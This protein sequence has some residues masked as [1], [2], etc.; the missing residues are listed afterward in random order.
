MDH[1]KISKKDGPSS[2]VFSVHQIA[3]LDER[4]RGFNRQVQ[5][6]SDHGKFQARLRYERLHI[7]VEPMSSEKESLEHLVRILHE[8]GYRQLRTQQIFLG[9]QYLGSQ[10]LWVDYDDPDLPLQTESGWRSWVR[11][12][13]KS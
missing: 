12:L 4:E 13:F 8:R 7:D 1:Q 5:I 2:S 9:D 3:G 6:L 11:G 10:E